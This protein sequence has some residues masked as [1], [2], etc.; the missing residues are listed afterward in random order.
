MEIIRAANNLTIEMGLDSW[1]LV[2]GT[3]HPDQPDQMV[4]LFEV[5]NGGI[6]CSPG[7]SR[8]R[9]I[10]GEG[11]LIP[12]DIAQ[13]VV[14]WAPESRN[15]RLGLL[16]AAKPETGYKMKWCALA[17]WPSGASTD[18]LSEARQAGQLLAD[19]I[20]RPFHLIPAPPPPV[21]PILDTQPFQATSQIT[22]RDPLDELETQIQPQEPPFTFENWSFAAVPKGYVWQRQ[23]QWLVRMMVRT[24][25]FSLLALL[26]FALGLG[27]QTSGLAQVNPD[28]LPW[29]GV[30]VA[31]LMT[32]L[33]LH[34]GWKLITVT[35]VV[36]DTTQREI[37][38]Q[39]RFRAKPLWSVPFGLVEYILVSQTPPHALGRKNKEQPMR[40]S[41]DVWL[42]IYD[43]RRFWDIAEL[44]R[45]EG[46]TH[47]WDTVRKLRKK[48][49]R[50]PLRLAFLDTPAHHAARQMSQ[51]IETAV[52][53]D[54]R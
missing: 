18:H 21:N 39:G 20:D 3:R 11:K 36:I 43:G 5:N 1:R 13:V 22:V 24:I 9:Q 50:Q 47:V 53:V 32:L 25:G 14:G 54:L 52:W 12:A 10:P 49:G 29:L 30:G 51:T 40:I 17:S 8:A 28:W 46:K 19:L 34:S 27:S 7:F 33:A 6:I 23:S 44:G 48:N 42:H 41:Q 2:N 38:C 35:D 31:V 4:A 15:W 37:R 45:V 16:L 26:F